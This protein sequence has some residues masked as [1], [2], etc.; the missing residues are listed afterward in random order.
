MIDKFKEY[1]ATN[2]GDMYKDFFDIGKP[3]SINII[4]EHNDT[5]SLKTLN[6]L[7][8]SFQNQ[9]IVHTEDVLKS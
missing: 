1:I 2:S 5:E 7:G 9:K 8:L 3:P 4:E 6:M